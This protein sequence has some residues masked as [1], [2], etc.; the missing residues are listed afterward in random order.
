MKKRN[1]LGNIRISEIRN[2]IVETP[3]T[4]GADEHIDKLL[5]KINEDLKTRHVYVIDANNKLI[6]SV[7][8]NSIVQYLFPMGAMMSVGITD[9]I[10]NEVNFFSKKV[11]EI[12]KK[13]PFWV[14]EN[15]TLSAIAMIM[16]NEMI[17]ELPVV[18]DEMKLIGQVNVYE[19]I[20]AYKLINKDETV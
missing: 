11:S 17:N 13:E 14:K 20:E 18:D 3:T 16:I 1:T 5:E 8:M 4:I 2:L 7:R 10:N 6:G 15:W 9:K 19:I 12:M